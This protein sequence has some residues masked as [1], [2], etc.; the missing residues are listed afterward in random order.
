MEVY[1]ITDFAKGYDDSIGELFSG[2]NTTQESKNTDYS[3][4]RGAVKKDYGWKVLSSTGVYTATSSSVQCMYEGYVWSSGDNEFY[5]KRAV[6]GGGSLYQLC[7]GDLLILIDDAILSSTEPF[8]DAVHH[9]DKFLFAD[10]SDSSDITIWDG[11]TFSTSTL[12]TSINGHCLEIFKDRLFIGNVVNTSSGVAFENRIWYSAV[13]EP[14]SLSTNFDIVDKEGDEIRRLKV[15]QDNLVVFKR[16]SIYSVT[17]TGGDLPFT[18]T[19]IDRKAIGNAPWTV[20]QG[21]GGLFFL[22]QEG[23]QFTD[24]MR[25]ET[26]KPDRAVSNILKRINYEYIDYAVGRVIEPLKQY[27]LTLPID[28]ST[29]CNYIIVYD[30]K[31]DTWKIL[32]KDSKVLGIFTSENEGTLKPFAAYT[33]DEI[34]GLQWNSYLLYGGNRNAYVG[35]ADGTVDIRSISYNDSGSAYDA[36]HETPWL[37]LGAPNMYKEVLRIQPAWTGNEGDSIGLQYKT[38]FES[39][40]HDCT[41][42]PITDTGTLEQPF[43]YLRGLGKRWKFKISSN[44]ADEYFETHRMK[45]YFNVRGER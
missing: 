15:F 22:N 4:I 7:P 29:T 35:N 10:G 38:D 18:N 44:N 1:E 9:A 33:G 14:T 8:I 23:I 41:V 20:D 13:G 31:H 3:E 34:A 12:A 11:F 30:Y 36:Y 17:W 43:V 6:V 26:I 37:D 40:W 32:E 16:N 45:I 39:D 19:P 2:P 21:P 27:W 42:A 28:G 5:N 24:G 25:V